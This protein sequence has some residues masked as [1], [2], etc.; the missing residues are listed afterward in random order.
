MPPW[1]VTGSLLA[2]AGSVLLLAYLWRHRGKPG[3]NWFVLTL[4]AQSVWCFSYGISLL[5]F[6]PTLRIGMEM[7]T[8]VAIMWTGLPFL[9]FGLEYTGRGSLIRTPWFGLLALLPV[10]TTVLVVTNPVHSLVWSEF[11]IDPVFG[12]ATVSYEFEAWAYVAIMIGT[13]FAASGTLL[14]FD[15]VVSYGP[16]YRREALAVGLS[17]LPPGIALLAWLFE[18]GPVPQLNLSAV[19]FLPHVLFDAYA[20]V[21][22]N[23]FTF[24]PSTRRRAD[25]SAI[26]DLENPFLVVDPN[27][28]IVD[29]NPAAESAFD[30][31]QSAVLGRD[32]EAV[33]ELEIDLTADNQIITRNDA[34]QYRELA[35]STSPLREST[36]GVV[37]YTV[38]LQDITDRRQ[39]KQ[40]L[41]VLN[42]ILR[43]NLR[44]DLNV[45]EGYVGIVADRTDDEELQAMLEDAHTDITGV[46]GM[47]EKAWAF[48]RA[49]DSLQGEPEPVSLQAVLETVAADVES[50]T[51]SRVDVDVPAGL[52]L[53]SQRA[54]LVQLFTNLAENAVVH[55]DAASPSVAITLEG[56]ADGV[57]V[58]S[59][60]DDGPG[61]PA[62]ELEVLEQGEETSLEHGSGLG[63]WLVVWCV[64]T[65]GGDIEF[66]TTDGTTVTVRLPGVI[67]RPETD[68]N[69]GGDSYGPL[70]ADGEA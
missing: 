34:G 5:V 4:V 60:V 32:L 64:R 26:E 38:L 16:L 36:G 15:T 47:A 57:A 2:G 25:Q 49:L 48:E 61:V 1:P 31:T 17:T 11:R 12:A 59:V 56:T 30:V 20:F 44:N 29:L 39:R 19:M 69:E 52:T 65:L 6:D 42:R 70:S 33:V 50:T 21:G 40:R 22:S 28:R 24:S 9:A 53:E 10:V 45:A 62:H 46:I 67:D 7:L 35:V 55:T 66:D 58:V 3:V 43:H 18:I 13:V 54:L 51:D 37:G 63:L 23:M 68:R 14:L 27:E 8:W 41:D